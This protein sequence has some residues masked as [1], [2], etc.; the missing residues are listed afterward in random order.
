[1]YSQQIKIFVHVAETGSF[2]KAAADFYVTPA[3]IMKQINSLETR[4][5]LVLLQRT[6]RGVQLTE[7]GAYLYQ[8]AKRIIAEA[9]A[10]VQKAQDIQQQ[11]RKTVRIGSSF[12][13][14]GNPLI[15][16]WNRLSP[17][18]AEYRFKLI[19]YDDDHQ[20]ILSVVA[21]LGEK[22]DFMVGVF[23]SKQMLRIGNFLKLDDCS[24]CVAVPRN[25]R[26]SK[27]KRLT[28][29]NLHGEHLVM[30]KG[31]DAFQLDEFRKV[32]KETHPQ[33][34]LKETDY[35]YDLE[36]FNSCEATGSLLLTLDAW[37]EVHPALV[38]LPVDWEFTVPYGLLYSRKISG[39]AESFLLE[40]EQLVRTGEPVAFSDR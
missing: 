4:L 32:I 6:S 26:L 9:E 12:L 19:P 17:N 2:S 24:L 23:D 3:S 20:Q 14:P 30:V 11:E 13:N 37:A 31:G 40:I 5:G 15:D 1:M 21:S 36:T 16:L 28:L 18:P 35:F 34:F 10:S 27:K 39:V 22:M 33:I 25:H 7:A 8:A 29:S 38:T